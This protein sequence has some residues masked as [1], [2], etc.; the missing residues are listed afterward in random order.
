MTGTLVLPRRCAGVEQRPV[1]NVGR[2]EHLPDDALVTAMALG[3]SA[4]AEVFVRRFERRVYGLAVSITRDRS[5]AEDVAQQ[6]FVRAWRFA[7]GYEAGRGTV[8]AWL[9]RITR[10][11][12]IDAVTARRPEPVDPDEL[13]DVDLSDPADRAV[14]TDDVARMHCELATIP[15]EQRRAVVLASIG[16]RSM[17]EIAEIE[18]VPVP[19]VKTRVRLGMQRLRHAMEDRS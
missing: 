19:T 17:A 13:F 2:L 14:V 11:Q 15:A 5:L 12:A 7:G 4:A 1:R 16:G 3:E 18:Q 8:V 6:A 9:L 10:N